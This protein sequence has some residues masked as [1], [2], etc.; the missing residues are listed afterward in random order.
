MQKKTPIYSG[1]F[2]KQILFIKNK[3]KQALFTLS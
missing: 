3:T 1:F 2:Y